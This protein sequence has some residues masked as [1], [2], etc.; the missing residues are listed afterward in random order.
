VPV[1]VSKGV[2]SLTQVF[3]SFG[4]IY[5][6]AKAGKQSYLYQFGDHDPSGCLIPEVIESRLYEFSE[7]Y[8]CQPP[9]V[10][11]VAL[12]EGQ[13]AAFNLPSRPTKREGNNHAKKFEGDSTELDALPAS[14]LRQLVRD[15]IEEHISARQVEILR[16]AEN[17]ERELI[18]KLAREAS[19]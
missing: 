16:E 19:S 17:S 1:V 18:E 10:E 7:Q 4:N 3:G 2:P 9:V 11:R 6:A 15:C 5:R 12:T 14:A 8:D 13:I